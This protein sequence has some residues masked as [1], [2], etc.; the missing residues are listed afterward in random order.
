MT[1]AT[2]TDTPAQATDH[3]KRPFASTSDP[4]AVDPDRPVL[5]R[6]RGHRERHRPDARGG[7]RVT[8]GS[9]VSGGRAVDDGD[10]THG[11]QLPRVQ[12]QQHRDDCSRGPA[13]P[14]SGRPRLLQRDHRETPA[15]S[16]A[17]PA[18]PGLLERHP[19]RGRRAEHRRQGGLRDDQPRRRTGPN[20]GQPGR[21]GRPQGH[22]RDEGPAGRAGLRHGPGRPH[23]RP[24]RDRQHEP[25]D[26]HRLHAHR[27]RLACCWSSTA[28]FAP[29]WF[30]SS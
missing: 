23:Q 26:H 24:G 21:A 22:R 27:H 14:R 17:H 25:E 18:H 8:F 28:R 3:P 29:P 12:L 1:H 16:R 4:R 11:W 10:E 5:D 6:R 9:D 13:A 30:S 15:R 7:R 2:P 19:D 20:A